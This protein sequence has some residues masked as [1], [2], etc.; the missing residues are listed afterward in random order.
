MS[1]LEKQKEEISV[2][3]KEIKYGDRFKVG[4]FASVDEAKRF[5]NEFKAKLPTYDE[6]VLKTQQQKVAD[7]ENQVA[8][9]DADTQKK[10]HLATTVSALDDYCSRFIPQMLNGVAGYKCETEHLNNGLRATTPL[11]KEVA[12]VCYGYLKECIQTGLNAPYKEVE[13]VGKVKTPYEKLPTMTRLK[14][15]LNKALGRETD[16]KVDLLKECDWVCKTIRGH[17]S[18]ADM[19]G[20]A[21]VHGRGAKGV[22]DDKGKADVGSLDVS[23]YQYLQG[24][25]K[26]PNDKMVAKLSADYEPAKQQWTATEQ[27]W[28]I[29]KKTGETLK[30]DLGCMTDINALVV[31]VGAAMDG[32]IE[33][34]KKIH[35]P[36]LRKE[37]KIKLSDKGI[38]TW[39][40]GGK[41]SHWGDAKPVSS[42]KRGGRD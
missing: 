23:S 35:D 34:Y 18:S 25:V 39:N 26:L 19:L 36:N 5:T 24:L 13:S 8:A 15:R 10:G 37:A 11:P 7:N 42:L 38:H 16:P 40:E 4:D 41:A 28:N 1:E 12:D 20:D 14:Y 21:F 29:A 22:A 33:T 31:N 3:L 6:E 30:G 9:L 32:K 27:A 17:V 2:M